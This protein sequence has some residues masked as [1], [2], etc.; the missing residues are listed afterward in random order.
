[1][2]SVDVKHHVYLL[3][4]TVSI[5]NKPYGLCGRKAPNLLNNYPDTDFV[6]IQIRKHLKRTLFSRT[7]HDMR[8]FE[9]IPFFKL[10]NN[11]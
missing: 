6:K 3:T 2:V 7:K 9:V 5:P 8:I 11:T 10:Q 1:M 4:T